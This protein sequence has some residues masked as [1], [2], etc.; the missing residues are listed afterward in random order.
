MDR[1]LICLTIDNAHLEAMSKAHGTAICVSKPYANPAHIS[2][3]DPAVLSAND[4][5]DRTLVIILSMDG[6]ISALDSHGKG[7]NI[8]NYTLVNYT[9]NLAQ[10]VTATL[11]VVCFGGTTTIRLGSGDASRPLSFP[12]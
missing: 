3:Q 8:N 2:E 9:H 1:T 4:K 11:V 10:A 5:V 12:L 7:K 6:A